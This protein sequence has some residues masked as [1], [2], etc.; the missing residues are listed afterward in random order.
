M[1]VEDYL[2]QGNGWY[3]RLH[4]KGGTRHH[5]ADRSIS[6]WR[7]VDRL[8]PIVFVIAYTFQHFREFAKIPVALRPVCDLDQRLTCKH[9]CS[10]EA[11]QHPGVLLFTLH[12][13]SCSFL[14]DNT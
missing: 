10:L 1:R 9:H 13:H 3:F 2:Q 14:A 7:S 11:T 4:E 5:L 12:L 8:G 6:C